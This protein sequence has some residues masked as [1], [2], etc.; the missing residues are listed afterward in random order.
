MR[1][2][3]SGVLVEKCNSIED[4]ERLFRILYPERSTSRLAWMYLAN[5]AGQADLYRAVDSDSGA[6]VGV[7]AIVPMVLWW[8][9][10]QTLVG[11][12]V[13]GA[14]DPAWRG[15]GVFS[16]LVSF[17][18]PDA[19]ERYEFLIGFPNMKSF[20]ALI[21]A[22]WKKI[23]ELE[24]RSYPLS[25]DAVLRRVAIPGFLLPGA[26]IAVGGLT[27]LHVKHAKFSGRGIVLERVAMWDEDLERI[28]AD[29]RARNPVC[30]HRGAA[31]VRWRVLEAPDAG[32]VMYRC[33]CDGDLCGYV[34]LRWR[35]K[36][37]ELLDM[38]VEPRLAGAVLGAL[39]R[40]CSCRGV[41]A[42]HAQVSSGSYLA[43][44][45]KR[46]GWLRRGGASVLVY[47][48]RRSVSDMRYEDWLLTH[49]DTDW[50]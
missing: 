50:L 10:R 39:S 16:S 31:F 33:A 2:S 4:W 34:A 36:E 44:A 6:V 29:V 24:G 41:E 32:Y 48:T 5:P 1:Q 22:G 28:E 18:F 47:S 12:A 30:G 46:M 21:R 45:L 3:G 25:V 27:R 14:V 13:D 40:E 37:V 49:A 11:Q 26:R 35:E 15:Q 43:R 42:M 38:M 7:Y 9:G 20:G 8:H 23:G 19:E 17:A